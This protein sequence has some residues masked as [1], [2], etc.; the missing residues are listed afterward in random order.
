M[1]IIGLDRVV[2]LTAN[3]DEAAAQFND[4]LGLD[5]GEVRDSSAGDERTRI[6]YSFP[7]F[8]LMEPRDDDGELAKRLEARGQGLYAVSLRVSD[9]ENAIAEL[10]EKGVEPVLEP[11]QGDYRSAFFHP[12]NFNGVFIE[13]AE[14]PHPLER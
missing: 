13:L 12:Q 3:A 10:A 7:G 8:E 2:V 11:E 14:Y 4:L 9:L 5:F 1:E 6:V